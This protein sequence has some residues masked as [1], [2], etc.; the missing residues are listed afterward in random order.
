MW[1]WAGCAGGPA[2]PSCRDVAGMCVGGSRGGGEGGRGS[3]SSSFD[4][5]LPE[6]F[7]T[8]VSERQARCPR[9]RT[10]KP[11]AQG[12]GR[13]PPAH[14]CCPQPTVLAS[15]P[16]R[17]LVPR[18]GGH[19]CEDGQPQAGLGAG[20]MMGALS[21]QVLPAQALPWASLLARASPRCFQLLGWEPGL[22]LVRISPD[23]APAEQLLLSCL[24]GEHQDTLQGHGDGVSGSGGIAIARNAAGQQGLLGSSSCALAVLSATMWTPALHKTSLSKWAWDPTLPTKSSDSASF[25][26][27][28]RLSP[29]HGGSWV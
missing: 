10:H 26:V 13:S 12:T 1:S 24:D 17:A 18:G 8:V 20:Q 21:L 25:P 29:P 2:E 23:A 7:Q 28:V 15:S 27:S 5:Q 11:M 19:V 9:A 6:H 14:P 16:R 4:K 22:A 3:S